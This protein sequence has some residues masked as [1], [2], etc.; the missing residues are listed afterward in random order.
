MV[1]KHPFHAPYKLEK[2]FNANLKEVLALIDD[3]VKV[4]DAI[5]SVFGISHKIY[6]DWKKHYLEDVGKGYGEGVSNLIKLFN[7][8]S[9]RDVLTQRQFTKKA[10][11]MALE[12]DNPDIL[13]FMLERR[14][15]FKKQSKKQ[16]DVSTEDDLNFNIN[17]VDS[18]KKDE[19]KE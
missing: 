17:I 18:V 5:Q 14:Y 2:G 11:Q 1:T 3:G 13:K 7:E 8:V 16:V 19:D 9:K 4:K 10:R 15:G 6:Y 12:E